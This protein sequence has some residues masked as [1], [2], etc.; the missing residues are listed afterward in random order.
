GQFCCDAQCCQRRIQRLGPNHCTGV[1]L[2]VEGAPERGI[3]GGLRLSGARTVQQGCTT[4]SYARSWPQPQS[5]DGSNIRQSRITT[6][7]AVK[8]RL[9][10][11]CR[12]AHLLRS[13][14]PAGSNQSP[15]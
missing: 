9:V 2:W 1:W 11:S 7:L 15:E 8:K 13:A 4:K 10:R 14:E 3:A 12:L 5:F 6:P